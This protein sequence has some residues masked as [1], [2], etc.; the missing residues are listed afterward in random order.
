[1]DELRREGEIVCGS[2]FAVSGKRVSVEGEG[3]RSRDSQVWRSD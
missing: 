1:M 3:G 2:G